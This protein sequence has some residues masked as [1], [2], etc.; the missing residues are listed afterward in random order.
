MQN[1]AGVMTTPA[2][3][4]TQVRERAQRSPGPGNVLREVT[5][6]VHRHA[7]GLLAHKR[8]QLPAT[9]RKDRA[10]EKRNVSGQLLLAQAVQQPEVC[11]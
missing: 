6:A 5:E 9:G 8:Q 3:F 10:F 7:E 4:C 11:A 1:S 2:L